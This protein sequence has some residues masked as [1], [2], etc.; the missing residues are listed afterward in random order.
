MPEI[1]TS[2][3]LESPLEVDGQESS[4]QQQQQQ[5]QLDGV[6]STTCH[7]DKLTTVQ[8]VPVPSS[9]TSD[10][11][12]NGKPLP[13]SAPT[14]SSIDHDG[15]SRITCEVPALPG[16]TSGSPG[17]AEPSA[18]SKVSDTAV[19]GDNGSRASGVAV[20]AEGV[21][22]EGGVLHGEGDEGKVRGEGRTASSGVMEEKEERGKEDGDEEDGDAGAVSKCV[23]AVLMTILLKT[24]P[25]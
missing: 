3:L 2:T 16:D 22:G 10:G 5:A 6:S 20:K 12:E 21:P 15:T 18:L 8:S 19:G 13:D 1:E 11:A 17:D 23:T 7:T 9:S 24:P 25:K 4:H 14:T